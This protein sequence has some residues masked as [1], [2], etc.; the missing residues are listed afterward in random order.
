MANNY[1]PHLRTKKTTASIMRDVCIALVPAI[2]GATV[3][4]GPEALLLILV[5]AAACVICEALWQK[6]HGL[7]VTV[8]DFSAVVTGILLAFNVSSKTPVWA[9]ILADIFAIIV[10]KQL[11]GGIGSNVV[12]PALMGRLF[13]MVVYPMQMMQYAEPMQVDAVS[14]ATIL[15]AVKHGGECS[16]TLM[17]AFIGKVPGALGET[18]ALLL[19]IGFA[20]LVI[21]KEV[22]VAVSGAFFATVVIISL[23]AGQDPLMQLCSGGLILGGCFMLTDYNLVS[24]KGNVLCGLAAGIIVMAIRIWGSFPEGVCYAILMV[25]CMSELIRRITTKHIYGVN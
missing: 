4:F 24:V 2:I 10:I 12:N 25:N 13:L 6:A 8:N 17:D 22:N 20:Y 3:F 18:S 14:S 9:V 19:L 23:V 16:Y 11:F 21:K 5:S 15:S 7:P 1:N